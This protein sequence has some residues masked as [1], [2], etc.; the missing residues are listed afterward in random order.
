MLARSRKVHIPECCWCVH[1]SNTEAHLS[2]IPPGARKRVHLRVNH[3][4]EPRR[5]AYLVI[6]TRLRLFAAWQRLKEELTRT[7]EPLHY[8]NIPGVY[9][10]RLDC[11]PLTSKFGSGNDTARGGA[12]ANGKDSSGG[13]AAHAQCQLNFEA[14]LMSSPPGTRILSPGWKRLSGWAP[15]SCWERLA[16]HRMAPA[17]TTRQH[18]EPALVTPAHGMIVLCIPA[19]QRQEGSGR[20][21]LAGPWS[22]IA[23]KLSLS[24]QQL[25]KAADYF[26][27]LSHDYSSSLSEVADAVGCTL[28]V[29]STRRGRKYV[30][31]G[32]TQHRSGQAQYT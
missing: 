19:S 23:G 7:N 31:C 18:A 6:R 17:A 2:Q 1:N 22:A 21:L 9:R 16:K 12:L 25:Q 20:R 30:G 32:S 14:T 27:D 8:A 24:L 4:R 29:G 11:S 15:G 13:R 10:H 5:A 28:G 3:M 26:T